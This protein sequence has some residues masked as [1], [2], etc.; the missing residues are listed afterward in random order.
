MCVCRKYV[1]SSINI[2]RVVTNV[3]IKYYNFYMVAFAKVMDVQHLAFEAN[4]HVK[5][6]DPSTHCVL[7]QN[8]SQQSLLHALQKNQKERFSLQ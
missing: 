2:D 3:Q 1:V 7:E 8:R 6:Q 4:F 5:L